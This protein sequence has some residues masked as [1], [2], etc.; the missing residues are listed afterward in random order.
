MTTSLPEVEKKD[1]VQHM[2]QWHVLL[3]NTDFHTVEWV[4]KLIMVVFNKNFDEAFELTKKI[5]FEGQ[6]IVVTTHKERAEMLKDLVKG[7][8]CDPDAT[9]G[10][11]VP[12]PCSIEPAD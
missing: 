11:K 1:K 5:H 4:V 6:C 8:G 3:H 9:K 10:P 7:Y 12:L 2:P